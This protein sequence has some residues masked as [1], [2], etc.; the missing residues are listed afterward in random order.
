MASDNRAGLV[1]WVDESLRM[2]T[3]TRDGLY[4]LGAVVPSRSS[5]LDGLRE[6]MRSMRQGKEPKLHWHNES[7]GRRARLASSVSALEFAAVLVVG[8]ALD[9]RRPVRAC[10]KCLER[11]AYEL[12]EIGV[13]RAILE[14]RTDRLDQV[15]SKIID[16]LR[17]RRAISSGF[18]FETAHPSAE[19]MLWIPD[20]V[21]GAYGDGVDGRATW[22]PFA[23]KATVHEIP[24]D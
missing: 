7:S 19:P 14:R 15:D 18:R 6:D 3:P 22:E 9:E 12:H 24:I 16:R 21:C 11:L 13:N 23:A 17:G 8:S 5:D 20:V 4:I 1:A 2:A 10:A